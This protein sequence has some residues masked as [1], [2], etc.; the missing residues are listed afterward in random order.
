MYSFAR[1]FV[2]QVICSPCSKSGTQDSPAEASDAVR[3]LFTAGSD[4]SVMACPDSVGG[5]GDSW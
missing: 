1:Y 5:L 3:D 2:M 4:S